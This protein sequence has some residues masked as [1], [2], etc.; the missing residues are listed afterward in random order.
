MSIQEGWRKE[1]TAEMA[2]DISLT[3]RSGA[4]TGK[5]GTRQARSGHQK[6]ARLL[7]SSSSQCQPGVFSSPT[8]PG[9]KGG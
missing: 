9:G 5:T 6:G 7:S 3:L 4:L 2:G 8:T 1:G